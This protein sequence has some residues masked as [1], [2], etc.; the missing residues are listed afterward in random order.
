MSCSC[1]FLFPFCLSSTKY[2]GGLQRFSRVAPSATTLASLVSLSPYFFFSSSL[3]SPLSPHV[4]RRSVALLCH[5][6]RVQTD[7]VL[8]AQL[9][10]DHSRFCS[11]RSFRIPHIAPLA[12]FPTFRREF[13]LHSCNGAS[14]SSGARRFLFGR[15]YQS[16]QF[17]P[18]AECYAEQHCCGS[19]RRTGS[20]SLT[21]A[22]PVGHISRLRLPPL[23]SFSCL[24]NLRGP[25]ILPAVFPVL[26]F[27]PSRLCDFYS[28]PLQPL[29]FPKLRRASF[30]S[31][32]ALSERD[33]AADDK[34]KR[35][36]NPTERAP[37]TARRQAR[38]TDDDLFISFFFSFFLFFFSFF[39]FTSASLLF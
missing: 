16:L 11:L 36:S 12:L 27:A 3:F 6:K 30:F 24:V 2:Y 22:L 15:C 38:S 29:S 39:S 17:A 31:S 34:K 8:Y 7:A 20:C 14:L 10:Q 37:P 18:N 21:P 9:K 19:R 23:M 25:Q 26:S 4:L 33:T 5:T 1:P 35:K 32:P 13:P 28:Q